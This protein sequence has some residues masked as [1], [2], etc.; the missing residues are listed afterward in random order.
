MQGF[1]RDFPTNQRSVLQGWGAVNNVWYIFPDGYGPG[2]GVGQSY[3]SLTDIKSNLRPRDVVIIGGVLREQVVLPITAYDILFM[4]AAN[5]PRQATDGGV[6]TGG[7]AT[8][9]AP[10]APVALTPLV[11]VTRQGVT[12]ENIL[13]NPPTSSAAIRLTTSG[14]LNEAGQANV[15]GCTFLGGGTGQIGVEDNGGSGFVIIEDCLFQLLT[16]TA[17]LGLT[18]ANAIPLSWTIQRNKFIQN[19]NDIKM[20]LSQALIE[21]NRFFAA[22]SGSTNKVIDTIALSGQ[23]NNNHVLLNQFKNVVTEI[24]NNNGYRGGSTDTWNN[25]AEGTAALIVESPPGAS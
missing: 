6:P 12:F 22:G 17:I 2:G 14:G 25:Y 4:G 10:L 21:A 16:G 20:S 7:G 24:K 19:T 8:W 13:F 18:T 15:R 9:M 3:T 1:W 23:G 5:I 11:E